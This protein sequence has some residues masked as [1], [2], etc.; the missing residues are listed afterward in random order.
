VRIEKQVLKAVK[1]AKG[2]GAATAELLGD[3]ELRGLAP[4]KVEATLRRLA[5][6]GQ[7]VEVEPGRWLPLGER[8]LVV[9]RIAM[10]RHGY[11]FVSF[12]GGDIYVA[13]RDTAGAMHGD[14]VAARL[15][16]SDG[17]GSAGQVVRIVQRATDSIVG[18]FEKSGRTGL[19]VPSDRR[20]RADFFVDSPGTGEART[21]DIVVARIVRYP[22][23]KQPGQAAVTEVLGHEGEPGVDIEII[24]REHAL[25][26]E[27]PEAV[28]RAAEAIPEDV[29]E[30]EAGREDIRGLFT[31]TIDPT[32]ARDFDDA[33]SLERVGKG[34]RLGVHIADVGHYVPWDSVIDQEARERSTSVYLVDRVL[35]MLPERLSN[36][37][38]SLKPGVDRF[39][40]TVMMDL[41]R[42]G[43]VEGYRLFPSVMRSDRRLAYDQVDTWL[44]DGGFP[45]DETETLLKEFRTVADLIGKRRVARGGLDFETVEPKVWLDAEGHP[46]HV[47]VRQRTTATNMIEEAMILANEVVAQHMVRNTAPMV[48]RIHED[49]D[50]DALA[51]VAVILKEFDYPIKDVHGASPLTFQKIIRFAH[52]RPEKLL[53]NSL[54]LRSLKR[55]RYAEELGKHFGLASEAYCHFTSPIRRY[56]DLIVHRLLRAQLSGALHEP[57]TADMVPELHWLAEHASIME[58]EAEHAEDD[59]VQVKLCELMADHI[60]EVYDG[61]ITNVTSFGMFVQLEN[62]AEGLVHVQRMTDDYY[63]FDAERFMLYGENKG[64]M[65]RLG[66]KAR[67]RITDVSPAEMRIDMEVA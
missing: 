40:F 8:G 64:R 12:P 2:R 39:S 66:E 21:A 65:F 55:A 22:T 49:P 43:L 54:V 16:R 63:R 13:G 34:W 59:S 19:I 4:G 14:T 48:F 33:I 29:G 60:G 18:R 51:Q 27:F 1:R 44:A 47:T 58:R 17:K 28:E 5:G 57:P 3:P 42:T 38:C 9:G 30:P 36:G 56:P 41:D 35:P 11:G 6:S 26:E 7:I 24:I 25:H 10:T 53:I 62:T 15:V 45:D 23:A 20:I 37:T 31:V 52:N 61:I 46:T 50:P 67:V 32:D